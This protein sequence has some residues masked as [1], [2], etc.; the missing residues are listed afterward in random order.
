MTVLAVIYLFLSLFCF[1]LTFYL[2]IVACAGSSLLH[3]G[4]LQLSQ[5]GT[6]L[7]WYLDFSLQWLLLFQS[8]GS[9]VLRFK[10]LQQAGSV[11]VAH[12]LQ[13]VDSVV[14]VHGLS[15]PTT[16]E[17]LGPRIEPVSPALGGGFLTTC[18]PGKSHFSP[19]ICPLCPTAVSVLVQGRYSINIEGTGKGPMFHNAMKHHFTLQKICV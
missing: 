3:A 9:R 5:V 15:C 4:F 2:C 17:I 12:R 6:T 7:Q 19:F 18:P 1:I 8:T 16:C 14:I 10:Q 13:S 11:I